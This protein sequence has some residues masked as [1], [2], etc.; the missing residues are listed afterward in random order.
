[1]YGPN[2]G[3]NRKSRKPLKFKTN[4]YL[5]RLYRPYNEELAMILGDEWLGVWD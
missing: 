2:N 4:Y 3:P 5:R 1:V